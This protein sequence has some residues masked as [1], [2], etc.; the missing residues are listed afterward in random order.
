M[1]LEGQK[2]IVAH[3]PDAVIGHAD[4]LAAAGFG[5]YAD[6]GGSGVERV[7]EQFLNDAGGPFDD[8]AGGDLVGDVVGQNPDATHGG[9]TSLWHAGFRKRGN[10]AARLEGLQ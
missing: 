10:T 6:F 7:F 4:Q 2:S 5:V 9:R 8:F 1:P 3:H